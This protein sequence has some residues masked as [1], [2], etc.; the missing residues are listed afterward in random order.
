MYFRVLKI[1]VLL[2]PFNWLEATTERRVVFVESK[3]SHVNDG[4]EENC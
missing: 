2:G 4:K 3:M 1:L